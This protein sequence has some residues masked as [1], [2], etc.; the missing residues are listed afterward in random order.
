MRSTTTRR[1]ATITDVARAASVSRQTVSNT[2][3]RPHLVSP[4]T[5]QRVHTEIERLGYRPSQAARN[6]RSQRAGAVGIEVNAVTRDGNDIAQSFLTELTVVAPRFDVHLV[7]F[8]HASVFPSVAGY[9]DMVRRHLVDAFVLSDTHVGDPRPQWLTER[10]IP[11]AAFGRI[12]DHPELHAWADVD[13][14][15]GTAAAVRHVKDQ[16]YATVGYLGWP[17]PDDTSI[18]AAERRSGWE[19]TAGELQALG[20]EAACEQ[21]LTDATRTAAGLLDHLQPGDAVVCA[22][23]LLALGVLYAACQRGWLPG[24]DLGIV[25]FDGSPIARRHQLT[26]VAQPLDALASGL[27]AIVHDQLA[28]GSPEPSGQLLTPTLVAGPTTDRAPTREP[29]T[30]PSR[31][32]PGPDPSGPDEGRLTP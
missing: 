6:M 21:D 29:R 10:G 32:H 31:P 16:G 28:G 11:F 2:L 15:A 30:T 1:R 19:Q 20:P 14:Q 4:Q 5:L 13:G 12:Y 23:D 3:N 26:S 24:P 27:L 22:S 8:A 17:R 9:Q 25:G 18:L 7:P